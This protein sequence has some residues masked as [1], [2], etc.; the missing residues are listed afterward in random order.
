M[1]TPVVYGIVSVGFIAGIYAM[2]SPQLAGGDRQSHITIHAD[3]IGHTVT[4]LGRLGCPLH[5]MMAVRGTWIG[6]AYGE[7]KPS[8]TP[9]FRVT[10]INGKQ[11]EKPVD[12]Y[13]YDVTVLEKPGVGEK[14]GLE[15]APVE[16]EQWDLQAYETRPIRYHPIDYW[17][18]LGVAPPAP[19]DR[20]TTRL[21]GVLKLRTAK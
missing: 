16:A 6:P 8:L 4:V 15:A 2:Y 12:F 18:A 20:G 19:L 5:E 9:R 3:D 11:L 1:R 10:R 13:G 21:S 17:Q 14:P 7:V